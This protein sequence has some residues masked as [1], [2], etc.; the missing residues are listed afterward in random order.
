[1]HREWRLLINMYNTELY[2]KYRK[3]VLMLMDASMIA[4]SFLAAFFIRFDFSV[5]TEYY[6]YFTSWLPAMILVHWLIFNAL[7]FY[8]VIWRFTSLWEMFKIVRVVSSAYVLIAIGV[9]S[10]S[11]FIGFPRSVFLLNYFFTLGFITASRI[12]VRVYYSH[13]KGNLGQHTYESKKRIILVGAGHTGGKIA[14]E[15]LDT[16]V[17]PFKLIGF[18]DDAPEKRFATLHG[19]KVLGTIDELKNIASSFDEILITL[20]S[21]SGKEMRH[22]I[23]A[24]KQTRK[25]FKTVPSLAELI[26]DKVSI[27]M[28]RDVSYMDLLGR[29]EVKLNRHSIGNL[30]DGKRIMITGAGGSIGSELVRQCLSFKPSELICVD[31]CE[32]HLFSI[33]AETDKIKTKTIIR[34]ILGDVTEKNHLDKIFND[35]RPQIVL[36]AA[37]FKHVPIQEEHPWAAVKT[38]IGGTLNMI[39]LSDKYKVETFV[40]VSTDK[41]VNPVNV[42]G[43][44]KRMAER[45]IQTYD[46]TSK[47]QFMAVRFGNVIGSSGSAIP[48][49]QQQIKDGGPVTITHPEMIRYFMSIPEASQLILQTAAIG[50]GGE[51]FLLEMGEPIKIVQ[52]ARDLIRLSG[53]EPEIDIPIV[54]TGLRPGEKLFEELQTK[55]EDLIAT[56]HKKI[57]ILKDDS[58]LYEVDWLALESSVHELLRIAENLELNEIQSFLKKLLPDYSPGKFMNVRLPSHIEPYSIKGQ[59]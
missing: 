44:S 31:N 15:I 47:T 21:A 27:S 55:E 24:C 4:I 18:V 11:G 22:I 38:N 7:G 41:A 57:M 6:S 50:R 9:W 34:S 12:F 42:M 14:K 8:N 26:D 39:K 3:Q 45:L 17:S 25:L 49:F 28:A 33:E 5:P 29:E 37:A 51:I 46:L 32:E 2:S 53:F 35:N 52:I 20:P 1:M 48:T 40:L 54:Y 36:H 56:N 23:K 16:S 43:A 59:A 13:Y 19:T 58:H 30:F 10:F